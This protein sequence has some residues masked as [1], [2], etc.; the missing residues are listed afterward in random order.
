[1]NIEPLIK[2]PE[3]D[4]EGRRDAAFKASWSDTLK[5]LSYELDKLSARDVTLKTMHST[6][7]FRIDGKL[8][9][10]TRAPAHPG[11]ILTFERFEGWDD[12]GLQSKYTAL[13]LP[14]DTFKYWK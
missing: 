12:E 7:D 14:C 1:M 4:T 11:V 10:D 13:R 8:R 3:P 6:E 9:S 2:W 5:L